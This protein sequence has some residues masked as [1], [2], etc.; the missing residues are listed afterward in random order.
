MAGRYSVTANWDPTW[1]YYRLTSSSPQTLD[2][3]ANPTPAASSPT[4]TP[5]SSPIKGPFGMPIG[6]FYAFAAVFAVAIIGISIIF[7]A[8]HLK[9][10]E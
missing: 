8:K 5:T 4:P 6:Y 9:M 10:G 7:Y 3:I 2:I 1:G